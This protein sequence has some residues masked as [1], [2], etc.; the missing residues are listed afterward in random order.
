MAWLLRFL[1]VLHNVLAKCTTFHRTI[2]WHISKY[3]GNLTQAK[4]QIVHHIRHIGLCCVRTA[5]SPYWLKTD[6]ITEKTNCN[7]HQKLES[8]SL[9]VACLTLGWHRGALTCP[10]MENFR[11]QI[12][13]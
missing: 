12:F 10:V 5:P 1:C 3:T 6:Q 11:I 8:T 13:L 9:F 4:L 2:S 7:I